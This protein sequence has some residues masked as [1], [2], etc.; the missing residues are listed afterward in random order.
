MIFMAVELINFFGWKLGEE[1]AGKLGSRRGEGH[2]I[3]YAI[4]K[5]FSHK[6][7]YASKGWKGQ[8]NLAVSLLHTMEIKVSDDFTGA[9]KNVN[10][11]KNRFTGSN[12]RSKR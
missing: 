2:K 1:V 10:Q 8:T 12:Y 7:H 9:L 3:I 5:G 11:I 6:A 4:I